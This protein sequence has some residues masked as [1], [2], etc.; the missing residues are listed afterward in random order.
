MNP[1]LASHRRNLWRPGASGEPSF[2]HGVGRR[3]PCERDRRVL[4]SSGLGKLRLGMGTA[5]P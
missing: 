5:I 1:W 3:L 4:A 2:W